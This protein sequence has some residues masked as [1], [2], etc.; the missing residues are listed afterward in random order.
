MGSLLTAGV[1][2]TNL[3]N[4]LKVLTKEVHTAPVVTCWAWYR[5]GSRNERP[6][7]TGISHWVEH[8]LF[9]GTRTLGKGEVFRQVSKRG[10]VLNG[11]TSEENTTYF[12]T[13][14]S[15]H[16]ELA[17]R[18]ES[19][20]MTNATFEPAEVASERTVIISERQGAENSPIFRLSEEVLAAAFRAHSYRFPVIGYLSDLQAMTREELYQYYRSYYGPNNCTL[21]LVGD[22]ATE[23][24]LRLVDQHFG[25]LEHRVAP[26]A[27]RTEEPPQQ[28]ER[29]VMVR[30]PGGASYLMACYHTPPA[31]HEDMYAL[32]VLDSVLSGAKP[33]SWGT[34]VSLGKSAR[35][36]RALV[37]TG[38]ASNANSQLDPGQDPKAFLL[39]ATAQ[40]G[41]APERVEAALL[42][43]VERLQHEPPSRKELD[44]A[45]RQIRAQ[46]AYASDGVTGQGLLLGGYEILTGWR[47]LEDQE[48]RLAAVTPEQ[49]RQAAQRYLGAD[50]RTL[51]LF[52]P[53]GPGGEGELA[54][55][56]LGWR[57]GGQRWFSSGWPGAR[58]AA[59]L[60]VIHRRV[61]EN[62]PVLL[63]HEKPGS[64][65]VTVISLV[66]AGA[67][68]EQEEESGLARLVARMLERG[69]ARSTFEQISDRLESLGAQ[70][71]VQ[72]GFE[73]ASFGARALAANLDLLLG[74]LAEMWRQ[75]TFPQEQFS[76]LQGEMTTALKQELDDT[77]ARAE[78]IVRGLVY[79][80]GHPYRRMPSGRLETLG[81]LTREQAAAFHGRWYRPDHLILAV[82]GAVETDRVMELV[83]R[84]LGDW[85]AQGEA[86]A[87]AIPA[88][89]RQPHRREELDL[90]H[91]SQCDIAI[92]YP[93]ISRTDPEFLAL[94]MANLIVGRLGLMG[95]LGDNVRDRQGLAYYAGNRLESGLGWAPWLIQAGVNPANVEQAVASILVEMQRIVHEPVG[96]PELADARTNQIGGLAIRLET[97][98]GVAAAAAEMEYFG[99]GIDYL[100]RF[101]AEVREMSAERI[102]QAATTYLDLEHYGL[103]IVGPRPPE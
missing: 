37:A 21:V 96:E 54:H 81:T 38:L 19:D 80:A 43:Q 73:T 102:Q 41:V 60:P 98:A 8:M 36:Y 53:T 69:T 100:E 66:K 27:V 28:G 17:L 22:F 10:G 29:R 35:L 9:K 90:P 23:P 14:P 91:K 15:Q 84:T 25:G 11:F 40:D 99:L 56:G 45:I 46:M 47:H 49:V 89:E 103:A 71:S 48:E 2:E 93:A 74:T 3:S 20:R 59:P 51:G 83:E 12:E 58:E 55:G 76:L 94:D 75:P 97:A 1:T 16:L 88:V 68:G 77:R 39:F 13:L 61:L 31:R 52:I 67:V 7:I 57:P 82:A 72:S 78:R 50:N 4:G 85:Q 101:L 95:R 6:G 30:R 65:G 26:L 86:P 63:V 5:V 32:S 33:L 44:K 34:G 62:G 42:E 79:Q 24:A 18:I 64:A 70:I 92:A 87:L